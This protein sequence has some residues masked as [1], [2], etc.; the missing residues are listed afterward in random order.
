MKISHSCSEVNLFKTNQ[1]NYS[2]HTRKNDNFS[3]YFNLSKTRKYIFVGVK[4]VSKQRKLF[5]SATEI[6]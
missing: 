4:L 6:I 2:K 3:Q 1:K 5:I